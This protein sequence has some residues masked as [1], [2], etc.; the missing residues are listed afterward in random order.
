[1]PKKLMRF[2]QKHVLLTGR[3]S[4]A[5]AKL[6]EKAAYVATSRGRFCCDIHTPE[7]ERLITGAI[8]SSL[9]LGVMDAKQ[10][11]P[12]LEVLKPT[13]VSVRPSIGKMRSPHPMRQQSNRIRALGEV[14]LSSLPKVI[15]V[16]KEASRQVLSTAT[17][18]TVGSGFS[19]SPSIKPRIGMRM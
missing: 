3:N 9:R 15:D 6:D 5:A 12:S 18:M 14:I 19:S 8:L 10:V 16:A 11:T 17:K 1:M 2:L 13:G 4:V 7:T